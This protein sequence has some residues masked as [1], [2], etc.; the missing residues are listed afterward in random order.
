MANESGRFSGPRDR[1][2]AVRRRSQTRLHH[3]ATTRVIVNLSDD[4]SP[5]PPSVSKICFH[6]SKV[7]CLRSLSFFSPP[8][9]IS[10]KIKIIGNGSE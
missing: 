1:E 5:D 4:R 9:E 6:C 7:K 8:F 3:G 2:L 10:V